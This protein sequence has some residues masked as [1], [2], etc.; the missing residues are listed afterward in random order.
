M[1]VGC[2]RGN[3]NNLEEDLQL[4]QSEWREEEDA[5]G[6]ERERLAHQ[7]VQMVREKEGRSL[8]N[9]QKDS[10]GLSEMG[11]RGVHLFEKR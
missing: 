2:I 9:C 11:G 10:R 5:R 1:E 7:G 6:V 3:F 8:P 4:C